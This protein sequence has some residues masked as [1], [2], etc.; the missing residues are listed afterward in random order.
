[1][2]LGLSIAHDLVLAHQGTLVL[3]SQPGKGSQFT[4]FLN[5]QFDKIN[6]PLLETEVSRDVK[7]ITEGNCN[8]RKSMDNE[9]WYFLFDA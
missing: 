6:K 9:R 2:G 3:D 1:M 5:S 7:I 4:I 8:M